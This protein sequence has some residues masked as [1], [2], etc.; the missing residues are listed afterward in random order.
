M[1]TFQILYHFPIFYIL[2]LFSQDR[3]CHSPID[4]QASKWM[5][6]D[7]I[8]WI[9]LKGVKVQTAIKYFHGSKKYQEL[10][11]KNYHVFL[12]KYQ[13]AGCWKM[14]DTTTKYHHGLLS[15]IT[16]SLSIGRK[17]SQIGRCYGW[18]FALSGKTGLKPPCL[19]YSD[20]LLRYPHCTTI[21]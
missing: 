14:A 21:N 2:M 5:V 3:N 9:V 13:L 1:L 7:F 10:L 11:I 17:L 16:S 18:T 12:G 6:W 8:F 4:S 15:L 20:V 19:L